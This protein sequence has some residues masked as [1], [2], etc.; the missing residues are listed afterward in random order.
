MM[1][2]MI[3]PERPP[4]PVT[5]NS[6]EMETALRFGLNLVVLILEDSAYG[7]IRR[8]QAV[9]KFLDWAL[10]FAN[11]DFVKYAESFGWHFLEH[12]GFWFMGIPYPMLTHT[13]LRGHDVVSDQV[14]RERSDEMTEVGG[15]LPLI[16]ES[17]EWQRP[18]TEKLAKVIK[19]A[20]L[21]QK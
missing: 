2:A 8:K 17:P 3:Y 12:G 11:P 20:G 1:A 10:T 4:S 5:V 15:R 13:R 14:K 6:Q 16:T 9:D 19:F 18:Q 21:K 7:M